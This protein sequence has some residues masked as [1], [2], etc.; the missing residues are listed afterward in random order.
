MAKRTKQLMIDELCRTFEGQ[1]NL[2][3]L[4]YQGTGAQ[5]LSRIRLGLG[6]ARVH[7]IV[8][9]N[10]VAK[11]ALDRIGKK[12]LSDFLQG[13]SAL[14]FGEADLLKLVKAV[15]DAGN[16]SQG[17]RIR[18]GLAEGAVLSQQ[19]VTRLA[20]I[21]S[22]EAL[23]AQVLC[24]I[25]GPLHGFL[26]VASGLLRKWVSLLQALADKKQKSD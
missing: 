5:D 21:P 7:L 25:A 8:V 13:P 6:R 22:Q 4:D 19:D 20:M 24:S 12:A 10:S 16:V 23:F 9:K 14:A 2:L 11:R 26:S 1:R 3:I 15:S 18:G 17:I